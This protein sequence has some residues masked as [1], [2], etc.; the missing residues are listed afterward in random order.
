MDREEIIGVAARLSINSPKW[1]QLWDDERKR[2][3]LVSSPDFGPLSIDD[4]VWPEVSTPNFCENGLNGIQIQFTNDN[5]LNLTSSFPEVWLESPPSLEAS[6]GNL[7]AFTAMTTHAAKLRNE[8]GDMV[9][10]VLSKSDARLQLSGWRLMG[11]ELADM[12]GI[13]FLSNSGLGIHWK[14]KYSDISRAHF[15]KQLNC[16][17]LFSVESEANTWLEIFRERLSKQ[18]SHTPQLRL[19]IWTPRDM[20]RLSNG[21]ATI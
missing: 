10:P 5:G 21:P 9:S 18:S 20:Y 13:S 16:W 3:H 14:S 4:A 7:V 19:G 1:A 17:G 15:S 2:I 6:Q 12:D 8:Y 11:Y